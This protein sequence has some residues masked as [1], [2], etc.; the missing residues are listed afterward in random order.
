M[1]V[2]DR[3]RILSGR[4]NITGIGL[5]ADIFTMLDQN[6]DTTISRVETPRQLQRLFQA[7]DSNKDGQINE[8][9]QKAASIVSNSD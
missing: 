2:I 9:E 1:A 6:K 8:E 5:T 3:A 7:L 4:P